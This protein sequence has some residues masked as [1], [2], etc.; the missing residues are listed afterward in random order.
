M[1]NRQLANVIPALAIAL[2]GV[3]ASNAHSQHSDGGSSTEKAVD[4]RNSY[5]TI[6]SWNAKPMGKMLKGETPFDAAA[7]TL[8]A[9]QLA[10]A[11]GLDLLWA[12]PE[13]S[14]TED[15]GAREEIWFDWEDFEQKFADFRTAASALGEAA[16]GGDVE[17]VK[18]AFG[19][20]GD[21]C[22][23]CHKPYKE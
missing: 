12:F 10:N 23:A 15:S 21:T 4:Y 11:S 22:K 8:H 1:K 20:V 7:F 3:A 18:S 17:A 13:G 14:V 9:R 16:E 6:L 5:M 2:G 19:K